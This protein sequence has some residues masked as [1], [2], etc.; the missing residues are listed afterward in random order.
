MTFVLAQNLGSSSDPKLLMV[1]GI[2]CLA[3]LVALGGKF[4][5]NLFEIITAPAASLGHHG[6]NDNF[7]FSLFVVFLGGM[8]GS[9]ILLI[10]QAVIHEKFQGFASAM[11]NFIAE[12]NPSEVYRADAAQWGLTQ[13][14]DNFE[15]YGISNFIFLPV[16][17]VLI[18]LVSGGLMFLFAKLLGGLGTCSDFLGSVAYGAMFM[19]IGFAM[20]FVL[21][22]QGFGMVSSLVGPGGTTAIQP[23]ALAIAGVVISLYGLVLFII[24]V[25]QGASLT[26]GQVVGV[27][28]IFLVLTGLAGYFLQTQVI[29]PAF[30]TYQDKIIRHNPSIGGVNL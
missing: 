10:N 6:K 29:V 21:D 2:I 8:I 23:D 11:A 5:V 1:M 13:A 20:S 30:D 17:A 3:V 12:G 22:V 18:W 9:V 14:T 7:F 4:F 15:L 28:L 27:V 19:T 24:G 16:V 26:G 25:T